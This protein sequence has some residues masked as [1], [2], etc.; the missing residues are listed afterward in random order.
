M[1]KLVVYLLCIFGTFS[2]VAAGCGSDDGAGV[3]SVGDSESSSSSSA[4]SSSG[5]SSDSSSAASDTSQ[6]SSDA[7]EGTAAPT[8]GQV[9]IAIGTVLD[10]DE[11][12]DDWDPYEGVTDD[13]QIRIGI[14]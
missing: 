4:S 9:E 1:K 3:R 5:S 8:S 14:S 12:P 2:L 11:C 13:G 7:E 6:S 10:L